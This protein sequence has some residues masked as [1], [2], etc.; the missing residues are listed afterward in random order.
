MLKGG[1]VW[2][3]GAMAGTALD[4][5]HGAMVLTDGTTVFDFGPVAFRAYTTAERA[6]LR[7]A[8]GRWP[9]DPGVAA[10]AETVETAHAQLLSQFEGAA[11]VGFHGQ[12]LAHDPGGRGTHQCGNGALLA[13]VLG[14]P[15]V[16]DFRSADMRLGGQG[17]PMDPFYL[18]ALARRL[19][20]DPGGVL[21]LGDTGA[22]TWINPAAARP[23]APGALVAFDTGPGAPGTLSPGTL[24]SVSG[25]PDPDIL[26]R[27]LRQSY[28]HRLPPKRLD[29]A[30]MASLHRDL[31]ELPAPEA[32]ATLTAA[33]AAAVAAGLALLPARP[34]CILVSGAG[35]RNPALM[36][37]LRARLPC[38]VAPVESVGLDGDRM[39]A[40]AIAHLAVR[41]A[42]GL[43]TSCPATTGVAAAVGGG[44]I[45][46][47]A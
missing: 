19:W 37:A 4:G 38:A 17:T 36:G 21:D 28:F 1:P 40:Q 6:I 27:F 18:F 23:D 45:S 32:T 44:E 11:L 8:Q 14:L 5:V 22:L 42:R 35:R 47:P 3:L 7:A 31:A 15:V 25:R 43:P 16:W 46:V 2:A 30:V 39:P 26:A 33:T 29:R 20:R 13:E 24:S 9:G 41:V 12:T 34:R 10:A